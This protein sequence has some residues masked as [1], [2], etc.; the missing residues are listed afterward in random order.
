MPEV[1]LRQLSR[2]PYEFSQEP[3]ADEPEWDQLVKFALRKVYTQSLYP[4]PACTLFILLGSLS[5][6]I[7]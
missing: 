3:R 4:L 6:F 1:Q 5:I 2:E 7:T